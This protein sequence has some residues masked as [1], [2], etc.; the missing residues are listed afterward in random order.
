MYSLLQTG[1][2]HGSKERGVNN[3]RKYA[4]VFWLHRRVRKTGA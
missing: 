1:V 4:A 2:K 3:T